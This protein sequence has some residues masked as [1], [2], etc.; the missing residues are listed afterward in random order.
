MQKFFVAMVVLSAVLICGNAFAAQP[1]TVAVVGSKTITT[2][3]L[4]GGM[5][6]NR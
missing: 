3:Q 4:E 6:Q 1:A 2:I 5:G